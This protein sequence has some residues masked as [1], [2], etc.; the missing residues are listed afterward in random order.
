MK[1][2]MTPHIIAAGAFVVFIVL[3]LAC[4]STES[5]S[6]TSSSYASSSDGKLGR[7]WY[8][9]YDGMKIFGKNSSLMV[10]Y[11]NKDSRFVAIGRFSN[12][13]YPSKIAYS[14]NGV[15]W[16]VVSNNP[17]ETTTIWD[18]AYGN[19]KFVA[20]GDEGK[21][22]YS[23]NGINWTLI[24]SFPFKTTRL[25]RIAYIDNKFFIYGN[26]IGA[27]MACSDD[28]LS[29]TIISNSSLNSSVSAISYDNEKYVIIKNNGK[30]A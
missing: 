8:P 10:A 27:R 29:W 20:V 9:V 15:N 14:N 23:N 1:K 22:A 25:A 12:T 5:A 24:T 13:N 17:F 4:A 19:G 26:Y 28:G 11:S 16:D 21:I 7:I 30:I 3:G 18:V 6:N 2:K